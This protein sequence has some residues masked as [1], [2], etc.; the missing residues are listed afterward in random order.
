MLQ[1]ISRPLFCRLYHQ[2]LTSHEVSMRNRPK[3][4]SANLDASTRIDHN[5]S[6][7]EIVVYI[8][9]FARCAHFAIE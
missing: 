5:L 9:S 6:E 7:V 3:T 4:S 8:R 2:R 1:T